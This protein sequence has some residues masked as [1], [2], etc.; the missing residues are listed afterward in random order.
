MARYTWS[1]IRT[2]LRTPPGRV[3]LASGVF[4]RVWPPFG[5]AAAAYR[6][7]C[8]RH[9][10]LVVVVGSLGKTTTTRAV[11]AALGQSE[12]WKLTSNSYSLLATTVLRISPWRGCPAEFWRS[13]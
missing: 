4:Y 13:R 12:G 1:E 9:R 10:R 8:I 2:M 11:K 7:T 6:R 3:R 5:L